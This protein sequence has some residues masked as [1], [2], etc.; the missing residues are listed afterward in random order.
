[1]NI[2]SDRKESHESRVS[3]K[4][5][6]L[7]RMKLF[8]MLNKNIPQ[9][10]N[11]MKQLLLYINIYKDLGRSNVEICKDY[12]P[13]TFYNLGLFEITQIKYL[14]LVWNHCK[15]F[16]MI[17]SLRKIENYFNVTDYTDHDNVCEWS[18]NNKGTRVKYII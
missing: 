18:V 1:M 17:W 11:T 10:I 4:I 9:K 2:S 6:F 12:D 14:Q 8:M 5:P 16:K 13:K 15:Y 3:N 7:K